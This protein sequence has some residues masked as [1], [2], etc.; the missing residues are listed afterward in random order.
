[1]DIQT[2]KIIFVQ[3]FLN[4]QNEEIIIGLEN[5]LRNKKNELYENRLEPMGMDQ[6]MQE[7]DLSLKDSE[8]G[9]LTSASDLKNK[10]RKWR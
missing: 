6:Y 1:M 9:R 5:L 8:E 3:E 10:I 4:L 7:I 2:R